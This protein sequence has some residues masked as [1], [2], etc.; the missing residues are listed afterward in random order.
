MTDLILTILLQTL[1]CI[2]VTVVIVG[3]YIGMFAELLGF[4]DNDR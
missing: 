4:F 1:G 2:V 3:P